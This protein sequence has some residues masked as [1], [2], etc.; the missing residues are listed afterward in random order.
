M[1]THS[2]VAAGFR[3]AASAV[4]EASHP[5]APERL[6]ASEIESVRERGLLTL[7]LAADLLAS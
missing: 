2:I 6:D 3:T 4:G 1:N 7:L 5:A